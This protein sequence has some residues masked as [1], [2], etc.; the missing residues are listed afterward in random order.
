MRRKQKE[1]VLSNETKYILHSKTR[2]GIKYFSVRP[3]SPRETFNEFIMA[4]VLDLSLT[5]L[6]VW[7]GQ[8]AGSSM[9]RSPGQL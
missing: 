2:C 1:V 4:P 3:K 9:T 8:P 5:D 7:V 6:Q